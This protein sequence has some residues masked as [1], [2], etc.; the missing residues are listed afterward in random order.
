MARSA[1][2]WLLRAR[3][4]ARAAATPCAA[5]FAAA[6]LTTC[7]QQG[8]PTAMADSDAPV[9]VTHALAGCGKSTLLQ[10]LAAL[11]AAHRAALLDSEAGS[12][13]L[14][15]IFRTRTLLHE[16]LQTL[17]RNQA[18]QPGQVIYGGASLP[19]AWRQACSTTMRPISRNSSC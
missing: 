4:A 16:F 19:V 9:H 10:C 15:F 2:L 12:Q 18:L 14:V 6:S 3:R 7:Q 13:V 17:M 1:Q 11:F 8:I 5:Y